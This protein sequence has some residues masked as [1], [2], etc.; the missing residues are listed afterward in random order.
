M[1]LKGIKIFKSAILV[2]LI[3]LCSPAMGEDS[4]FPILDQQI[5][6][7]SPQ[8]RVSGKVKII[9]SNTMKTILE[10]WKDRLGKVHPDL[11]IILESGGS[12]RE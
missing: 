4:L 9:G 1:K 3:L 2:G 11:D 6:P 8:H 7:Y 10:T 5:P 12:T